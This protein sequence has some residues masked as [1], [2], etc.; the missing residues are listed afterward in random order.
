MLEAFALLPNDQVLRYFLQLREDSTK[1]FSN[2]LCDAIFSFYGRNQ[3]SLKYSQNSG[4]I[5]EFSRALTIKA[6]ILYPFSTNRYIHCVVQ[7]CK[8][9]SFELKRF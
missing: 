8:V 9:D 5:P 6:S 2:K 4:F 7:V 3:I 1:R